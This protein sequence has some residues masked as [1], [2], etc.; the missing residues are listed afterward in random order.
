[1]DATILSKSVGVVLLITGAV[2]F[3][4][5]VWLI[6]KLPKIDLQINVRAQFAL[7]FLSILLLLLLLKHKKYDIIHIQ[8]KL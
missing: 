7:L 4:F 1:M 5:I 8:K 2:L 6:N 3:I